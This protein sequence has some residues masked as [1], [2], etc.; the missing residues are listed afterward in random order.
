MD[1]PG[2]TA[3][4]VTTDLTSGHGHACQ[5]RQRVDS[6]RQ[7]RLYRIRIQVAM[8]VVQDPAPI[9][10]QMNEAVVSFPDE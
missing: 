5:L 1:S 2:M 3:G 4:P 10:H 7:R 8:Q 6:R 9:D